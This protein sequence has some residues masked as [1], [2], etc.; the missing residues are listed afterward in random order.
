MR[1]RGLTAV[2]MGWNPSHCCRFLSVD[3]SVA[4]VPFLEFTV[5]WVEQF[6]YTVSCGSPR[7]GQVHT[8]WKNSTGCLREA[9]KDTLVQRQEG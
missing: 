2:L 9:G 8:I 5:T 3:I 4:T 6:P 1:A 7:Y